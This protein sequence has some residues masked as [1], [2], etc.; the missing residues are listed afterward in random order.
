LATGQNFI[1]SAFDHGLVGYGA[2]ER[3]DSVGECFAGGRTM[4]RSELIQPMQPKLVTPGNEEEFP[5]TIPTIINI[6]LQNLKPQAVKRA[7]R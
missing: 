1:I 6:R 2:V 5:V 7:L 4:N 3:H